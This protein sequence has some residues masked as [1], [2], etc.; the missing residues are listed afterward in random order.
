MLSGAALAVGAAIAAWLLVA[1]KEGDP[2]AR[3]MRTNAERT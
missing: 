1:G 2:V 3:N